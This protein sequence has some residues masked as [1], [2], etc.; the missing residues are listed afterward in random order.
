[1][2]KWSIFQEDL[3]A[4]QDDINTQWLR[5]FLQTELGIELH[6]DHIKSLSN[7]GAH[8]KYNWQIVKAKD[9]LSKNNNDEHKLEPVVSNQSLL[10]FLDRV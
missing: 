10:M 1:M 8:D 4:W 7:N 3:N 5:R 9:N 2:D 6:I